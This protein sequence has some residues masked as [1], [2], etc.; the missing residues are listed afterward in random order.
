[1]YKGAPFPD[2][3][4]ELDPDDLFYPRLEDGTALQ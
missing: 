1:M 2:E 3:L 4:G